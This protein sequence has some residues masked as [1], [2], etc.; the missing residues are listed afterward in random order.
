MIAT[1]PLMNFRHSLGGCKQPRLLPCCSLAHQWRWERLQHARGG[2]AQAV[3]GVVGVAHAELKARDHRG[4]DELRR[5][6]KC[7]RE[8]LRCFEPQKTVS[9]PRPATANLFFGCGGRLRAPAG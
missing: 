5:E 7:T 2:A 1:P 9:A 6:R 3:V 8:R 4:G